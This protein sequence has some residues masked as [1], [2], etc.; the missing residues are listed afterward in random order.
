MDYPDEATRLPRPSPTTMEQAVRASLPNSSNAS[1]SSTHFSA[2]EAGRG[3]GAVHTFIPVLETVEV[4]EKLGEGSFGEVFRVRKK[5]TPFE[6]VV[7][8]IPRRDRFQSASRVLR[9]EAGLLCTLFHPRVVRYRDFFD[10]P[11][12]NNVYLELDY[13]AGGS[14]LALLKKREASGAP[15]TRLL[16]VTE[17]VR[18]MR[19]V[20]QALHYIHLEG[21]LHL[22]IK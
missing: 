6:V 2:E 15:K 13:A 12:S 14:L 18:I 9:A 16:R 1:A 22:D 5:T 3:G 11:A 4:L 19:D 21:V 10:D 17:V 8:K 7:I 20:L